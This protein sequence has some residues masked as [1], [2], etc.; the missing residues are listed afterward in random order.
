MYY[1]VNWLSTSNPS[2]IYWYLDMTYTTLP[3]DLGTYT[4]ASQANSWIG[5][6]NAQT[7]TNIKIWQSSERT[8]ACLVTMGKRVAF[9]WPGCSE[10]GVTEPIGIGTWDGSGP[11]TGQGWFFPYIASS[12]AMQV[13]FSTRYNTPSTASDY[14]IPNWGFTHSFVN[15]KYTSGPVIL[16]GFSWNMGT[17]SYELW[18]GAFP[19]MSKTTTDFG[20]WI[21]T[22]AVSSSGDDYWALAVA[23]IDGELVL[24]TNTNNYWLCAYPNQVNST[25]AAFNFG[26]SEPDFS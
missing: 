21:P 16:T 13:R 8:D 2:F 18:Q 7:S 5:N 25:C 11:I 4:S 15:A 20:Q 6:F 19:Y 1:W 23:S 3:G 9:F 24:D 17:G 12:Q 26:T 22:P 14:L 10:W